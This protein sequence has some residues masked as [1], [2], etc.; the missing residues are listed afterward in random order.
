MRPDPPAHGNRDGPG[1]DPLQRLRAV[2]LRLAAKASGGAH[3]GLTGADPR[4]G[5]R[6]DAGQVWAHLAEFPGYWLGEIERLVAG[7]A[8]GSSE[9]A[10]FGRTAA[11]GDRVAIIERDRHLDAAA[12]HTRVAEEIGAAEAFLR[13]LPPSAW[14]LTGRH[15]TLGVMTLAAMVQRFLVG[16]LEEHADQLDELARRS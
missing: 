9:P 6:W 3:A 13:A 4:T 11:D 14:Q 8:R 16:H 1:D 7:Q 2:R 12:L 15:P 10:P 5:E